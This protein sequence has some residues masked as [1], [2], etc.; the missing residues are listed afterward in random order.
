MKTTLMI[1]LLGM[2][3]AA[4]FTGRSTSST[5]TEKYCNA[6]FGYCIQYD[7]EILNEDVTNNENSDGSVFI[8]PDGSVEVRVSGTY[9]P[10]GF[11]LDELLAQNL[12]HFRQKSAIQVDD[13]SIVR[14]KT[15]YSITLQT[16]Q[17]HVRQ[18]LV[19]R[20]DSY[21]VLTVMVSKDRPELLA[22]VME[23]TRFIEPATL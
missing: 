17:Y 8:S 11:G 22:R 1:L 21:L 14:S 20:P 6:R 5:L 10:L 12:E 7:R 18:Q 13:K 23:N 3:G 2:A 15:G 16:P 19:R 4:A 9:N